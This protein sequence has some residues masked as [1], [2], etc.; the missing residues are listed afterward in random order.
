MT[1]D[2]YYIEMGGDEVHSASFCMLM[3]LRRRVRAAK[4][5]HSN[6]LLQLQ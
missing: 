6:P 3:S 2:G 1:L 5:C 4:G